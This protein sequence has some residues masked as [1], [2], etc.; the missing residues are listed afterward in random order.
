MKQVE[1]GFLSFA[2]KL[3]EEQQQMVHVASSQK[4]RG[5][6]V[7]DGRFDSNGCG[8]AKVRPNY[9]SMVVVF[10][11]AHKGIQIFCFCIQIEP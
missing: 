10:I 11:L 8:T 2:S 7:K 1:L 5:R 3:V 6:E 4:S 9:P